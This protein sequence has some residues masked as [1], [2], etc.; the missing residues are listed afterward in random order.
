MGMFHDIS[1]QNFNFSKSSQS[2]E[3]VCP[4]KCFPFYAR[5]QCPNYFYFHPRHAN[6]HNDFCFVTIFKIKISV[7]FCTTSVTER[8][9]MTAS[10]AQTTPG[11]SQAPVS[12]TV[13]GAP[14]TTTST[15]TIAGTS[16]TE[17]L[18]IKAGDKSDKPTTTIT[19]PHS[20]PISGVSKAITA[21]STKTETGTLPDL[22]KKKFEVHK[23]EQKN[24]NGKTN[25]QECSL[26][27]LFSNFVLHSIP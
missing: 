15:T 5:H 21:V 8:T 17:A 10:Q 19:P 22:S 24:K 14:P 20:T 3:L 1:Q 13:P 23:D 25:F 26:T 27:D 6:Y 12:K 18:T 9:T 16:A 2:C 11:S 4:I 7:I